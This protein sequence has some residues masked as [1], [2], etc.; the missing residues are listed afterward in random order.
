MDGRKVLIFQTLQIKL[1][2][3]RGKFLTQLHMCD[4]W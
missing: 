3:D 4:Q 1:Y 2:E